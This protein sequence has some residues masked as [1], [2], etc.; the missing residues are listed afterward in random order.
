ME[1]GLDGVQL[2]L[3]GVQLG[4]DSIRSSLFVLELLVVGRDEPTLY[5][6]A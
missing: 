3:D 6:L 1:L 4:V 2:G 5:V